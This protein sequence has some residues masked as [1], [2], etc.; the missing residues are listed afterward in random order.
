MTI[1]IAATALL[2]IGLLAASP[3]HA[4]P[5]AYI[6]QDHSTDYLMDEATARA[7]WGE[8]VP[9]R[10][11]TLYPPRKW[12]FASEVEGGFNEA[13]TCVVTARAM[14]LPVSATGRHLMYLPAKV[15]GAFDSIPNATLDQCKQLSR[16]KL[17]EAIQAMVFAV[18]PR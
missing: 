10:L 16:R 11:R 18:S 9:L 7:L 12:G 4:A 5:H 3:A 15:A 6:V 14:I 1:G 13:K 17:R 2:S 8:N